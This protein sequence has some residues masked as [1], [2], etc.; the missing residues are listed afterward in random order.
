[1]H[2]NFENWKILGFLGRC[3]SEIFFNLKTAVNSSE[4]TTG[5][6]NRSMLTFQQSNLRSL[7]NM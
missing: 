1:M 3:Q 5:Q 4:N 2:K 7:S 6:Q